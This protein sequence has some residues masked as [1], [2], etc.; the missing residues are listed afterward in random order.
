[1]SDV[2]T[3]LQRMT[4]ILEV[5]HELT[6]TVAL[7]PL[8]H[9]IVNEAADLTE[10]Q[11]ASILL[12]DAATQELRFRAAS[13]SSSGQLS[14]IP[15]PVE[16]S[17][18]GRVL[19]AKSPLIVA[20]VREEPAYYRTVAE[21]TGI[22]VSSLMGVPL[23]IKERCIGV[24]EAINKRDGASFS[25]EDVETL[26]ALAAQAAVAIENA[27]LVTALRDAY[28]E[29]EQLDRMKSDFIAIASHELRS[30]LGLILGYAS[31]LQ[32][33][34]SEDA[35]KQLDVIVRAATRLRTIMETMLNLRYLEHGEIALSAT[36]FDL[37]AEVQDISE[38]YRSVAETSDLELEV[39]LPD[40][41]VPI[42][43]DRERLRVVL[44]NL[45]SNAVKFNAPG[46]RVTVTVTKGQE[47]VR[48]RVSDSGVGIAPE[49]V[50]RVFDRFYQVE[51]PMSRRHGGIGLGL[52]IVRE[53]VRLHGGRI[54]VESR[55]DQG[56]TFYV[57]LPTRRGAVLAAPDD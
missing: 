32:Q 27:R 13:G 7:E 44:E 48:I 1:M 18:A 51:D 16:N 37:R 41:E 39:N 24:L 10:T 54:W 26:S 12:L 2:T 6:S 53:L 28:D 31:N 33:D 3:K 36:R 57:D 29:L 21:K 43:A 5:T 8:L 56:S 50:E 46:G 35:R 22:E 47:E 49:H 20:D 30:P 38:L 17:I 15:V 4:R 34:V 25:Q 52:A 42:W 55:P 9:R 14:D 45:M 11:S 40:E 19:L 23:K